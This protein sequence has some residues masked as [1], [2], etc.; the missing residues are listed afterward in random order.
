MNNNINTDKYWAKT[1]IDDLPGLSV[2]DHMINVGSVACAIAALYP[3][4]LKHFNFKAPDI[5]ALAA[6][7]DLGKISPG[8]QRK[9]EEWIKKNDLVNVARNYCWDTSME[10]DHG[11]VSQSA[12][13]DCLLGIGISI[14]NVPYLAAILAAHHGKIKYYPNPRGIKPPHIKQITEQGSGINW[15]ADRQLHAKKIWDYFQPDISGISFNEDTPSLWWLA[16]I[17]SIADWIGSDERFFSPNR[18]EENEAVS[19]LAQEAIDTIGF[20][21]TEFVTGLSFH[22]LF[23]D[24]NHPEAQWMPNDMQEKAYNAISDPGVYVIEAPMGIGKTEAALWAAY[25]LLVARKATGIYFALPTQ[26]TSNRMHIRMQDYVSRICRAHN[27]SRLIHGNSWLIDTTPGLLP[28]ATHHDSKRNDARTGRDWFA[29][30]KRALIAPFGVGTVDQALLGVVAAKHFFVRHFALAGKVVI[31]DEIHSYDL[32]T[33]SL[34]DKL[35]TTLESLRCTVIVLSAT[36]TGKRRGQIVSYSEETPDDKDLSYPLITG[37]KEEQYLEPLSAVPPDARDV[38]IDFLNVTDATNDAMKQALKG[39]AVLWVSNTVDAAQ[40]QFKRFNDLTYG[41]IPVGLL[42]ARFP[43]WRREI[44]ENEWMQRLG[45]NGKTRCASILVSTQIV[46][47]SVDIDADLIITELA[48]TDM[49]LQRLGRLW[50]HERGQRPL[51]MPRL[52]II[53]EEKELDEFRAMEPKAIIKSLGGKAHVYDP[54][55]L[56][57]TLQLWKQYSQI[58]IPKQIRELIEATYSTRNDDPPAW[59]KLFDDRFV[60][61]ANDRFK[62]SMNSNYWQPQLPDEEGVQ[63]RLNDLP[64]VALVLCRHINKQEATFIDGTTAQISGDEFRLAT[65]QAIHKNLVKVPEYCFDHY[66]PHQPFEDYLYGAQCVGIVDDNNSIR[67]VKG[68]SPG[69]SFFYT[70]YLGLV[71]EK[72]S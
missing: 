55:V 70:D 52:C 61:N 66:E 32:Y 60:R 23:H 26:A 2:Y 62:A 41:K 33:G 11:K 7:H 5:G 14:N 67:R 40:K 18:R 44:I 46:E 39:G 17:T 19:E 50:R 37:R 22:D 63:T 31:L 12:I 20:G 34:I 43:F 48:P 21:K 15:Q 69:F 4:I 72:S 36:L 49:L 59:E 64:T 16:G 51:K 24:I 30:A 42:H 1:T 27:A 71:I 13:H 9:C 68:L 57:R 10:A 58:T 35:I 38:K 53:K 45:K 47:Q 28:V 3:D 6:L 25:K 29:S 65:A 8:F 54:F 56:L